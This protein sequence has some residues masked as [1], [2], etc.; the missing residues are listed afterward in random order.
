MRFLKL[1][2][3][4]ANR[5]LP[6]PLFRRLHGL[7]AAAVTPFSFSIRSG[8]L[9]SS[10]V[11]LPVHRAGRPSPSLT[12]RPMYFLHNKNVSGKSILEW[13]S[14]HSTLWWAERAMQVVSFE[15]DQRW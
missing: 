2:A 1:L 6:E 7:V 8:H 13:G 9:R 15:S 3:N 11:H 14:G 10:I 12:S 4:V 5:L